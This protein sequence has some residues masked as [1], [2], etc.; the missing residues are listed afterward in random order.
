ML[1]VVCVHGIYF[2]AKINAVNVAVDFLGVQRT[3]PCIGA[4]GR[5]WP[6]QY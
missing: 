3:V 5:E 1:S 4:V 6:N 2:V